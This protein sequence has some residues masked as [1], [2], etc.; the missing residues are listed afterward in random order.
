[1]ARLG[2]VIKTLNIGIGTAVDFLNKKGQ[3]IEQNPS[4][5][6]TDVQEVLLNREFSTDKN[7]KEKSDKLLQ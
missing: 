4:I 3:P 6:L 5:K 2:Q 1:M 7:M